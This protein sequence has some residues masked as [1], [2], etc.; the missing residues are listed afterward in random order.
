M[1]THDNR[2]LFRVA[3]QSTTATLKENVGLCLATDLVALNRCLDPLATILCLYILDFS[4]TR[5][6]KHFKLM[7]VLFVSLKDLKTMIK[8]VLQM[9]NHFSVF[10]RSHKH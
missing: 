7:E 4:Y 8:P 5:T 10:F 3:Q 6:D 2:L 1:S 9:N